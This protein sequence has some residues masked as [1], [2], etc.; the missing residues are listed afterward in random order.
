MAQFKLRE[1]HKQDP[2]DLN[3]KAL[4]ENP[5]SNFVPFVGYYNKNTIITKILKLHFFLG[6]MKKRYSKIKSPD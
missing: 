4:F 6:Y 5:D 1:A 2:N 3:P